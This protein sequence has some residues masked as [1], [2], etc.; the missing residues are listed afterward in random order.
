[1]LEILVNWTQ[2]LHYIVYNNISY[3]Y[4]K[5]LVS[6]EKVEFGDFYS[7][8]SLSEKGAHTVTVSMNEY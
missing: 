2:T 7:M 1:M 4:S 5:C 6:S 8:C 3:K